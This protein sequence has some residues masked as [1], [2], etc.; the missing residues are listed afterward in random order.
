MKT[1][2]AAAFAVGVAA[3]FPAA[4]Q[5]P[6]SDPRVDFLGVCMKQGSSTNYCA[7]MSES[8]AASLTPQQFRIYIDYLTLLATTQDQAVL[9][10][11]LK[12]RN[13]VSGKELGAALQAGMDATK[14][15]DQKCTGL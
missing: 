12:E 15:G 11:T 6:V 8:L 7:C 2:F 14:A 4:A 10:E 13:G 9:I 5:Q 1:L 3:L